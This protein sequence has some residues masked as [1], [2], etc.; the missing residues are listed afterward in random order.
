MAPSNWSYPYASAIVAGGDS[1]L[2]LA[3]FE[4]RRDA[5]PSSVPT[6]QANGRGVVSTHQDET[7]QRTMAD[8]REVGSR[9]GPPGCCVAFANVCH[10]SDGALPPEEPRHAGADGCRG[11]AR[12]ACGGG[13]GNADLPFPGDA[14]KPDLPN[15]TSVALCDRQQSF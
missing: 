13:Q 12:P 10:E 6:H 2:P 14:T 3:K 1:R 15:G 7:V 8:H 5:T 11:V 9:E 4:G